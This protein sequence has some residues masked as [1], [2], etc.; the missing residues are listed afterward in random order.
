[1]AL[2]AGV[3][4]ELTATALGARV[5]DELATIAFVGAFELLHFRD[6]GRDVE[7]VWVCVSW[8]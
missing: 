4:D 5:L 8:L 1:V 2:G 6:V 3:L 7:Y